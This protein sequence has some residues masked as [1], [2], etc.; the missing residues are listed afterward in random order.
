MSKRMI[1]ADVW[2]CLLSVRCTRCGSSVLLDFSQQDEH[3]QPRAVMTPASCPA[4]NLNATDR[5]TAAVAKYREFWREARGADSTFS[6]GFV[7]PS[8]KED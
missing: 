1:V 6:F 3:D 5:S 2:E 8:C 4:C 7:V